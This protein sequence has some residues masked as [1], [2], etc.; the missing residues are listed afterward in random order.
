[1]SS[2]RKVYTSETTR[3]CPFL[4]SDFVFA[5]MAHRIEHPELHA[6][7][8]LGSKLDAC[9]AALKQASKVAR[10]TRQ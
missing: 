10:R 7:A 5:P 9:K 6:D 3:D 4:H 1:M 8:C 2:F